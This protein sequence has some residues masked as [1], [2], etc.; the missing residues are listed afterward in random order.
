MIFV[1]LI[2]K[3]CDN[4]QYQNV[5]NETNDKN[6]ELMSPKGSENKNDENNNAWLMKITENDIKNDFK[7]SIKLLMN[8]TKEEIHDFNGINI[9]PIKMLL[10]E[11]NNF[12]EQKLKEKEKGNDI[13][14]IK[15]CPLGI[16]VSF[17]GKVD[18]RSNLKKLMKNILL[19]VL[20]VAKIGFLFCNS[21]DER[22]AIFLSKKVLFRD[23]RRR[24]MPSISWNNQNN[25][26]LRFEKSKKFFLGNCFKQD[27]EIKRYIEQNITT[28]FVEIL[29]FGL[30]SKYSVLFIYI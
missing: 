19:P 12:I 21:K 1:Q 5:N 29:L 7:T 16:S 27:Y 23:E 8:K 11:T 28:G 20:C 17:R 13:N 26:N 15:D 25:T 30:R 18:Q 22:C 6:M 2:Q 3:Q 10:F 9:P 24:I 4:E 14:F